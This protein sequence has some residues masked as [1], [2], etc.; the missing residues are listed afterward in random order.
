MFKD[1]KLFSYA[2][3]KVATIA[4]VVFSTMLLLNRVFIDVVKAGAIEP[5]YLFIFLIFMAFDGVAI[6]VLFKSILELIIKKTPISDFHIFFMSRYSI[7]MILLT[8]LIYIGYL[9]GFELFIPKII[10]FVNIHTMFTSGLV[11]TFIILLTNKEKRTN[12]N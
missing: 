10:T 3:F 5:V 7:G 11:F 1:F 8:A 4:L 2:F 9:F 6:L 12:L